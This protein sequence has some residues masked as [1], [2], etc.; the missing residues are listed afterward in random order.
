M[1]FSSRRGPSRSIVTG[2]SGKEHMHETDT[3]TGN[4][5]SE[6]WRDTHMGERRGLW[7]RVVGWGSPLERE[8]SP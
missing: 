2:S 3:G 1:F 6:R 5:T 4:A 8:R 7:V